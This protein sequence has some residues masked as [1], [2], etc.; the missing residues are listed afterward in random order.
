MHA[1]IKRVCKQC[2]RQH[3]SV[4]TSNIIGISKELIWL[5]INSCR[6]LF[7][8]QKGLQGNHLSNSFSHKQ[9]MSV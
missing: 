4:I 7:N 8:S 2:H 5:E 1:G 3:C 6:A 9:T